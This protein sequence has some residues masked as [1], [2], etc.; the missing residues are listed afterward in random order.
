MRIV[1]G[2]PATVGR[3]NELTDLLKDS[4]VPVPKPL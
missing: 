1:L 3:S 2:A 4:N